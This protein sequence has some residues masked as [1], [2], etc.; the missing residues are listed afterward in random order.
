MI[1]S[2]FSGDCD[3][4]GPLVCTSHSGETQIDRPVKRSEK[5]CQIDHLIDQDEQTA[6]HDSAIHAM[7]KGMTQP[8]DARIPVLPNRPV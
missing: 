2:G 6:P 4:G 3:Q 8:L 5:G 1:D 7:W